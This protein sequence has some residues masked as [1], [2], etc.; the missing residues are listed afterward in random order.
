MKT[1]KW[2]LVNQVCLFDIMTIDL[3]AL[4][5]AAILEAL[6]TINNIR[7]TSEAVLRPQ[8]VLWPEYCL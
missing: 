5:L 8:G 1:K 2:Y 6:D 7:N 3:D 4:Q